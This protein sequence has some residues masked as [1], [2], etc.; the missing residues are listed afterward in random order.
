MKH[1]NVTPADVSSKSGGAEPAGVS[2]TSAI[3]NRFAPSN[4]TLDPAPSTDTPSGRFASF[5]TRASTDSPCGEGVRPRFFE[6]T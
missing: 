3:S 1:L 6:L 5:P 4:R 2:D